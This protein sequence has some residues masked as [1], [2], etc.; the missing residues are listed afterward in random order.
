ME[1]K[2]HSGGTNFLHLQ[3]QTRKKKTASASWFDSC[4]TFS[5]TLKM[6]AICSSRMSVSL[7]QSTQHYIPED[8]S[9]HI[10][11]CENLKSNIIL[12]TGDCSFLWDLKRQAILAAINTTASHYWHGWK[13]QWT[14]ESTLKCPKSFLTKIFSLT[15]LHIVYCFS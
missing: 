13:N 15:I 11:C 6:E 3:D 8:R 12:I 10:H 9:L 2:W 5:L 7:H 14:R 1:A 4:L